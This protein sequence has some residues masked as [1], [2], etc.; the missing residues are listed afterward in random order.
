M[1]IAILDQRGGV[2][3]PQEIR[4]ELNLQ[5]G[6]CLKFSVLGDDG[7]IV[8]RLPHQVVEYPG[9]T[10]SIPTIAEI[11]QANA[12]RLEGEIQLR[13]TSWSAISSMED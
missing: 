12:R 8:R 7:L 10:V 1:T 2:M 9:E 4:D 11:D 3:I 5:P 6:D 13:H